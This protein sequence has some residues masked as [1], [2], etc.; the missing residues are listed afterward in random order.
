M[1][2][3]YPNGYNTLV[4]EQ[5]D[6]WQKSALSAIQNGNLQQASI[7]LNKFQE[8]YQE[9]INEWHR[10]TNDLSMENQVTK[11]HFKKTCDAYTKLYE[12]SQLLNQ[13]IEAL[14][15]N[16][17]RNI[18]HIDEILE[19]YDSHLHEMESVL[20]IVQEEQAELTRLSSIHYRDLQELES[21]ARYLEVATVADG[22]VRRFMKEIIRK[23]L[24]IDNLLNHEINVFA[25]A[26]ESFIKMND[27]QIDPQW[28]THMGEAITDRYGHLS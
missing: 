4:V 6:R 25:M 3:G 23:D 13:K 12:K 22:A 21:D 8:Y 24:E 10:L 15:Q 5:R 2:S 18:D 9:C 19:E 14:S 17:E 11:D 26:Y 27:M 1:I 16:P 28:K 20:S 7:S